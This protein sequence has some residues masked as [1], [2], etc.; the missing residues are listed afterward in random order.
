MFLTA[1]KNY[2]MHIRIRH[3]LNLQA[4]T[5]QSP[6]GKRPLSSSLHHGPAQLITPCLIYPRHPPIWKQALPFSPFCRLRNKLSR[7]KPQTQ[8]ISMT[9]DAK[10]EPPTWV[11]EMQRYHHHTIGG[12]AT[13]DTVLQSPQLPS[14]GHCD[15]P[16]GTGQFLKAI[17]VVTLL[18]GASRIKRAEVRDGATHTSFSAQDS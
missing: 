12:R 8:A 17:L 3:A 4:S 16:R 18:L 5:S 1:N 14:R 15:P 13:P 10:T 9:T 11:Q 2:T 7:T 6:Q